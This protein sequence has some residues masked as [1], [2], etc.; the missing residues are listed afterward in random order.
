MVLLLRKPRTF[1]LFL[2][3]QMLIGQDVQRV[4]DLPLVMPF[5]Y[6][7]ILFPGAP[8]SILQCPSPLLKPE[9][10]AA[11]YTITETLW[12]RYILAE[13]GIVLLAPMKVLCDNF[14]ATYITINPVL[15]ERNNHMKVD[16]HFV[17][18]QVSLGYLVVIYIH[19]QL[20]LANIFTK[21]LHVNCSVF[22]I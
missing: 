21:A 11:A 10:I 9:Y 2:L 8:K 1:L 3:I 19:S 6:V 18:E 7:Q 4:L 15:H 20:Q 16:Y 13:L 14:S 17:C 22:D 5:S 12:V